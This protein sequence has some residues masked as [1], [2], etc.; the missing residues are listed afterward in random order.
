MGGGESENYPFWMYFKT[1]THYFL[2][3]GSW[4]WPRKKNDLTLDNFVVHDVV[5]CSSKICDWL[6]HLLWDHLNLH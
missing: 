4:K 3:I 5:P 6:L 1:W 2:E